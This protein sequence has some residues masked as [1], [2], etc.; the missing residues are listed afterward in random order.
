MH[1]VVVL[2]PAVELAQ[3]AGGIGPWVDPRMVALEGFHEGFGH[4]VGLRA[5]DRRR[6]RQQADL[7]GQFTSLV[8][9]VGRAVVRQPLNRQRQ[10][11]PQPEPTLDALDHQVADVAL[12]MPPV[13]ATH[14]I[15][16]RCQQSRAEGDA[17]PLAIVAADFEPVGTPAY[18][19][20]VDRDTAVMPPLDAV[21]GVTLEQ[22]AVR[23]HDPV[24]ALDV[25]H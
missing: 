19:R 25:A 12:S 7:T 6:A 8:R 11:A 2:E 16:S 13:V 4:A 18:V 21:A 23:F 1:G 3:H 5:F 9:A 22:K 17:H 20:P 15:A 14:E 10:P 24:D